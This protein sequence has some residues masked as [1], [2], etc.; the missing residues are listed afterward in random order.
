[1]FQREMRPSFKAQ[2]PNISFADLS[3][4]VG[5]TWTELPSNERKVFQEKAD[6]EDVRRRKMLEGLKQTELQVSNEE[7]PSPQQIQY[8]DNTKLEKMMAQVSLI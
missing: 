5:K 3:K 1:M 8:I 6:L 4:L 7:S 2:N